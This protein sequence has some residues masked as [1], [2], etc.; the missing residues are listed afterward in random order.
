LE[1]GL[2]LLARELSEQAVRRRTYVLRVVYACLLFGM[3]WVLYAAMG[4]RLGMIGVLGTGRQLFDATVSLQFLGI[5]LFMPA[6]V[7]GTITQEKERST[8]EL[9]LLTKLDS[10]TIV[11]EK[12]LSRLIAML[13]LL[14]LSMPLLAF[15]YMLGGISSKDLPLAAWVAFL[16]VLQTGSLALLC[17][18]WFRTTFGAF[19]A[20][21]LT[22]IVGFSI[23]LAS[24]PGNPFATSWPWMAMFLPAVYEQLRSESLSTILG[25]SLPM[26]L[27]TVLCVALAARC[28]RRRAMLPGGSPLLRLFHWLDRVVKVLNDRYCRGRI[29]FYE[30]NT[31]PDSDP[32]A[33][34]ETQKTPL[35][36]PRFLIRV[37][38]GL[39]LPVAAWCV[40]ALPL[41]FSGHRDPMAFALV[42]VWAIAVLLV[43]VKGASLVSAERSHQTLDVLLATPIGSQ[44]LLL[45]KF[46]GIDRLIWVLRVP[47]LTIFLC[48]VFA[49]TGTNRMREGVLLQLVM[50][51]ADLPMLAWL[52]CW[53]SLRCRSQVQS[54]L[55][56]LGVLCGWC[57]LACLFDGWFA[58][59]AQAGAFLT[60]LSPAKVLTSYAHNSDGTVVPAF[61]ASLIL[62][63]LFRWRCL[64]T[65]SGRLGRTNETV[66]VR[67]TE[68]TSTLAAIRGEAW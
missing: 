47:L 11:V 8:L 14:L 31:L 21:Y 15:A 44:D 16:A 68:A 59:P 6:I 41:A 54:I 39:E 26:F 34:R 19:V 1:T 20:V 36:A 40:L 33:W 9:L 30:D 37:L 24:M 61:F 4:S 64:S 65:V 25:L 5:Y 32:V 42:S 38:L 57:T 66:P 45:Q 35:G 49:F 17:S 18:A 52:A 2:P 28:L 63:A 12:L 27:A 10:G 22:L 13:S 29:I 67:S 51:G 58:N 43:A 62:W 3:F 55:A 48:E 46:R 60:A 56:T 7:C 50:L 23:R 53:I